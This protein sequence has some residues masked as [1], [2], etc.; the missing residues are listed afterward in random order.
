MV[1]N[2]DILA[3]RMVQC[4]KI[5]HKLQ[6]TGSFENLRKSKSIHMNIIY[7]KSIDHN[8][9]GAWFLP[10][11]CFHGSAWFLSQKQF[12][13]QRMVFTTET[14]SMVTEAGNFTTQIQNHIL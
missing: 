11:K 1:S 6:Q 8:L 10:Q 2:K 4:F 7:F 13:W 14:V 5:T 12:P 3:V 9:K